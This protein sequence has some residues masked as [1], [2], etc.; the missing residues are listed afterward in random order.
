MALCGLWETDLAEWKDNCI[1]AVGAVC[2][3]AASGD[4][5]RKTLHKR[6]NQPVQ[7]GLETGTR[8]LQHSTAQNDLRLRSVVI[9]FE[10]AAPF[11]MQTLHWFA[12]RGY[13]DAII[14][15]LQGIDKGMALERMII[16]IEKHTN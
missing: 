15:S 6:E 13:S 8:G 9:A 1:F 14:A 3:V 12:F 10:V 5:A 2:A 16:N 11:G 4:K 7:S